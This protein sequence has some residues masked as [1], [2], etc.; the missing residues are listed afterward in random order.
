MFSVLKKEKMY[1][2]YVSKHDSNHENKV[3][4]EVTATGLEP[5]TT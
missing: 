1:P 3:T 4:H 2:A 5:R